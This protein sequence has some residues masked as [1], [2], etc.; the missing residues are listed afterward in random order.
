MIPGLHSFTSA[1][2]KCQQWVIQTLDTD[3]TSAMMGIT[4][5]HCSVTMV[6]SFLI[7]ISVPSFSSPMASAS[8]IT[9]QEGVFSSKERFY[10]AVSLVGFCFVVVWEKTVFGK[11]ALKPLHLASL[12]GNSST[13]DNLSWARGDDTVQLSRICICLYVMES[14]RRNQLTSI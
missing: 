8:F 10:F 3:H 12:W 9:S 11:F 6:P 5:T 4:L 7:W 2:K 14:K 13:L 1:C